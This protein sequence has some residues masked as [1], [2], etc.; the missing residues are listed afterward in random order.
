MNLA[1]RNHSQYILTA[2]VA[3]LLTL[4]SNSPLYASPQSS[5]PAQTTNP[6]TT[7]ALPDAPQQQSSQTTQPPAQSP[8]QANQAQ[9]QSATLAQSAQTPQQSAQ[10]PSGAAAAKA[11]PVRGAPAAEPVGAAVAP[12]RQHSH[13][14][15]L[16]K[17]GL[18]AGAGVA[19]GSV[20]ALSERSPTRPPGTGH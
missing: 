4:A 7:S 10:S 15:L 3:A 20:V 16:I 1:H 8:A 2:V 17:A 11:A 14:S 18:L 9:Q 5:D 19:L 6:A 13:R 12:P